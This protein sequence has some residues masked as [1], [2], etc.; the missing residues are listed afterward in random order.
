MTS[1]VVLDTS[2][3]LAPLFDEPGDAFVLAAL[4]SGGPVAI[5]SVNLAESLTVMS[6][7][8]NMPTGLA[9]ERI[10]AMHLTIV[11]FDAADA[12][13]V[14]ELEPV[15]RRR[16]VSLGDAACIV[17]ARRLDRPVLTADRIWATLDLGIEVRLIR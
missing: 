5:S 13:A 9:M 3:L 6:R 8:R 17:L 2:A 15:L 12:T 11:P 4:A 1:G 7:R 16:G 10:E 14:G